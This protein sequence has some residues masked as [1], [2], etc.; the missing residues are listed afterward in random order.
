M[1]EQKEKVGF[2]RRINR[3][4]KEV[5]MEMKKVIW[6]T[7]QQLVNYTL[8]VFAACLAIGIVVWVA[9]AGLGLLFT[10]IFGK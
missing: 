10:F 4:F 3:F 9:D 5:R 6:P 2:F 7:R 1:A 8:V